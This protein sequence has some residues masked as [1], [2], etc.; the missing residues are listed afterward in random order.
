MY[1]VFYDLYHNYDSLSWKSIRTDTLELLLAVIRVV[2]VVVVVIGVNV[3]EVLAL[4][5]IT[6]EGVVLIVLASIVVFD[7]LMFE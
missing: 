7:I 2:V 5:M 3:V 4:G 6:E 1:W